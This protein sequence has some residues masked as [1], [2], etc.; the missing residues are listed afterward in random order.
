MAGEF[1]HLN[2]DN[3]ARWS[4]N[5]AWWDQRIGDGNDFQDLL[6]EPATL[7]LLAL[8]PG[9][10]VLDI[11]CGGGRLA[12]R[13]AALG[14]RV[15]AIDQAPDFI[16]LARSRTCPDLPVDYR[17]GDATDPA[18][19]ATLG[20]DYD[21]IVCTMALMDMPEIAPQIGRASCRE[22]V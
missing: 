8:E 11:A 13:M 12:R 9:H 1:G 10:R 17:V 2:D 21:R 14:A 5:A 15:T 4:A 3:R 19:L 6:I 16:D 18:V 7:E 22:R 20:A